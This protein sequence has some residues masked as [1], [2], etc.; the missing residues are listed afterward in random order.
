MRRITGNFSVVNASLITN[1]GGNLEKIDGTFTL[2][3]IQV[4]ATLSFP[5]LTDVGNIIWNALPNLQQLSFTTGINQVSQVNIQN[6]ELNNLD[7]FNV[8]VADT[9]IIA[10]NSKYILRHFL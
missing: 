9:V 1:V 2:D 5:I 10:N 3:A 6:S 4:L 7:G 8:K